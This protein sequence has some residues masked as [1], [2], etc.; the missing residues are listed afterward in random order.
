MIMN[1]LRTGRSIARGTLAAV[2]VALIAAA[3]SSAPTAAQ[4]DS[5][6]NGICH[7][8]NAKL[9]SVSSELVLPGSTTDKQRETEI[10]SALTAAEQGSSKLESLARPTGNESAL[11]HA[12]KS[13]DAQISDLKGLLAA[14]KQNDASKSETSETAFE[15]SE[16]PLNQQ[17]DV[18]GLSACGSG[19]PSLAK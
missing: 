2:A 15:E 7:T 5:N 3:C 8:Y 16:A 4:F 13:Q 12:F 19:S 11:Q 14:I 6:A 9:K 1:I 10:S 17:F 18:L